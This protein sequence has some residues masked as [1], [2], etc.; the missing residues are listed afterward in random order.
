MTWPIIF[1]CQNPSPANQFC[2]VVCLCACAPRVWVQLISKPGWAQNAQI[3]VHF[4]DTWGWRSAP[5]SRH[6]PTN[7]QRTAL[8]IRFCAK[9]ARGR[10]EGLVTA[11][12]AF[13]CSW[14]TFLPLRWLLLLTGVVW[15]PFCAE[16]G[17]SALK[18]ECLCSSPKLVPFS[19]EAF[20]L[21]SGQCPPPRIQGGYLPGGKTQWW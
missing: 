8:L 9:H 18:L 1:G 11:C 3:T 6:G 19:T 20:V 21:K 10:K 5:S 7:Y 12:L 14:G 16:T 2:P 17:A 4:W 13:L 15:N